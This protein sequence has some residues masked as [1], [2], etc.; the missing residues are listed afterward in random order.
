MPLEKHVSEHLIHTEISI[1]PVLSLNKVPEYAYAFPSHNY[2][3]LGY[4]GR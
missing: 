2:A 4:R 1:F 3:V